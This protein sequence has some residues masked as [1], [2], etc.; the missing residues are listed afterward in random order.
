MVPEMM[1]DAAL[2][3][4]TFGGHAGFRPRAPNEPLGYP[5]T[6]HHPLCSLA[7]LR[8]APPVVG[9]ESAEVAEGT[10]SLKYLY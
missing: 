9:D 7:S 3:P 5:S 10:S 1:H 2:T 6:S 4:P 8:R